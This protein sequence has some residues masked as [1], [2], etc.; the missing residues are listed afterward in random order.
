MSKNL[1]KPFILILVFL[2]FVACYL[3]FKPF[4]TEIF[5]AAII[6][7]VFYNPYLRFTKFLKGRNHLAAILMC[8]LLL[9]LIILPTVRFIVYAGGQSITAYNTTVN[10]FNNHTINDL[11]K[12]EVFHR[13]VL[14]YFNLGA[15]NFNDT[16]FQN[17]VLSILKQSSNWLLSGASMILKSTTDFIISLLLIIV[18]MYFFFVDGDKM[19]KRIMALTPWPQKYNQELFHKFQVVSRSTFLSNFASAAAQGIVGGIGFGIV[20]FPP[21][22]AGVLVTLF[23]FLPLGSTIFYLPMAI[24][25]LLI[26]DIWQGIFILLW[27][28]L[29]ISTVDNVIRAYMIKDEAQIN[30]IFVLLSILGGIGLFGFWGVVLGPLLVALAVTIL[31]IY[32]LEFKDDL[33]D[34][35]ELDSKKIKN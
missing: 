18:I 20:G 12:S 31:H 1:T 30:P 6:V 5:V 16:T 35:L 29:I 3:V 26:G 21:L 4:L 9:I 23:S 22:L 7:S 28:M 15:Y 32:E 33:N 24:F 13:G 25:Y 14:S 8:L 34:N 19:L 17:T 27:G 2:V 11:L 10:F